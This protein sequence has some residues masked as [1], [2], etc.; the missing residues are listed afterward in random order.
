MNRCDWCLQDTAYIHYHDEE[1]GVPVF[2]DDK[3][4]EM[5]ILEGMQ[6]GLSWLT[7]LR[8]RENFR[9]AFDN[10]DLNKILDYSDDYL[11]KQL[12]NPGIIRHKLKVFGIR[13]NASAFLQIQKEF[14]QFS[15]YLWQFVE[16]SPIQNTWKLHSDVPSSSEISD[17]MSKDLKK[18]GF[19]F[20]G[21]TICYAFMQAIGMVNDHVVTCYRHSQIAQI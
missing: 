7:I 19:T 14:G 10:F 13:K 8:K 4:F 12:Q 3:L 15:D 9:K 20:V 17:K 11:N 18:R 5:L 2:C 16:G 21:S 6:A 1:W